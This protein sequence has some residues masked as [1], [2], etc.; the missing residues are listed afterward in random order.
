MSAV[1]LTR[2]SLR[3]LSGWVARITLAAVFGIAAVPKLL[4]PAGFA[5]AID[6]YHLLPTLV[7]RIAAV[8]LPMLELCTAIAVLISRL[9]RGASAVAAFLLMAFSAAMVQAIV[10]D[11]DL[12]CGCFGTSTELGVNWWTVAR[13]LGLV[14]LAIWSIV[15][16]RVSQA[17]SAATLT[18]T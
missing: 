6:N 12:D 4:D 3:L 8:G 15:A 17:T 13:N 7:T 1:R 5:G 9:T 16:T 2:P 11:I 18:R 10:R 14:G